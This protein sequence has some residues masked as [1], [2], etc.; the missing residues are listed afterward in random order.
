MFLIKRS[1]RPSAKRMMQEYATISCFIGVLFCK[2]VSS[3]SRVRGGGVSLASSTHIPRN[4][5]AILVCVLLPVVDSFPINRAP[6]SEI[7]VRGKTTTSGSSRPRVSR[8]LSASMRRRRSDWAEMQTVV[9]LL[10]THFLHLR[11]ESKVT[12]RQHR[13][14]VVFFKRVSEQLHRVVLDSLVSLILF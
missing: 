1:Q 12:E 2:T 11:V 14:R 5:G 3:P 6:A 4:S 10:F 8:P 13:A 7:T 9:L